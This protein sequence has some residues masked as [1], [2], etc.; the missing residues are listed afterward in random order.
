MSPSNTTRRKEPLESTASHA[1]PARHRGVPARPTYFRHDADPEAVAYLENG[2]AVDGCGLECTAQL[3]RAHCGRPPP[4][5][6]TRR[7]LDQWRGLP[8]RHPAARRQSM[9]CRCRRVASRS[10]RHWASC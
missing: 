4:T 7:L 5:H 8:H 3:V 9:R 1:T 10:Q 2:A 6:P